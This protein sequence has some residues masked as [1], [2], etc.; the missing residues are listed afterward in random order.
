VIKR[1]KMPLTALIVVAAVI[2]VI[3]HIVGLA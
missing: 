3:V 2:V 1:L